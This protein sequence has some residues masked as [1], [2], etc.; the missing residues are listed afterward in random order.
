MK[1]SKK[2]NETSETN[3]VKKT[4]NTTRSPNTLSM[5]T[6]T[7]INHIVPLCSI[8]TILNSVYSNAQSHTSTYTSSKKCCTYARLRLRTDTSVP[9]VVVRISLPPSPSSRHLLSSPLP[10]PRT[11]TTT[12]ST[13]LSSLVDRSCDRIVRCSVYVCRTTTSIAI[14]RVPLYDYVGAYGRV[15]KGEDGMRRSDCF[16]TYKITNLE[17]FICPS[18]FRSYFIFYICAKCVC[19]GNVVISSLSYCYY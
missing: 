8:Q 9:Y 19:N 4:R 14:V 10:R 11:T 15:R 5:N 6:T 13:P 1:T 18:F 12:N 17:R 2:N 7:T 3:V 16:R